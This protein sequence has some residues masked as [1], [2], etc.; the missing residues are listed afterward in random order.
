MPLHQEVSF[1]LADSAKTERF[2]KFPRA[3]VDLEHAELH[4]TSFARRFCDEIADDFSAQT[5]PLK[6]RQ[7]ENVQNAQS[8]RASIELNVSDIRAKR[9]N[10]LHVLKME[11]FVKVPILESF[12]PAPNFDDVFPESRVMNG[13]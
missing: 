6:L 2:I 3:R 12:V 4:E 5:A 11:M 1:G 7:N 9:R 13:L 8:I 10:E